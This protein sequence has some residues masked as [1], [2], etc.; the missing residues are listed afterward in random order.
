M[1]LQPAKKDVARKVFAFQT[2]DAIANAT[3]PNLHVGRMVI[4][5][6]PFFVQRNVQIILVS[7]TV[8]PLC[9]KTPRLSSMLLLDAEACVVLMCVVRNVPISKQI[10]SMTLSAMLVIGALLTD[11]K[12]V[13]VMHLALKNVHHLLTQIQCPS[14]WHLHL[15]SISHV[16]VISLITA[17][18][19]PLVT[20]RKFPRY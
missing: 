1:L 4:V 8:S 19:V 18:V 15:A 6:V 10:V 5:S 7:T 14:F 9:L 17:H 2:I 11:M 13:F 12:Q 20:I 3:Y 16:I